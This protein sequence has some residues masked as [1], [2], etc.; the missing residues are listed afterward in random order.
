M[1]KYKSNL[2]GH[3]PVCNSINLDWEDLDNNDGVCVGYN[4]ICRD[5]HS[6]GVEWYHLVFEGHDVINY[7]DEEPNCEMVNDYILPGCE[8]RDEQE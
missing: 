7:K 2:Q 3:C 5:C 4:W 8:A 6:T 1:N